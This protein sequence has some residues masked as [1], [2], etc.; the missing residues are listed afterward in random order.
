MLLI[1]PDTF[2]AAPAATSLDICE[3]GDASEH[4]GRRPSV[5]THVGNRT[6]G[7]QAGGACSGLH[8]ALEVDE[9]EVAE[10]S[11]GVGL[12]VVQRRN[13]VHDP[14][15]SWVHGADCDRVV[16]DAGLAGS[17]GRDRGGNDGPVLSRR[18]SPRGGK[19]PCLVM[20]RHSPG[21]K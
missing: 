10:R 17:A 4:V 14:R 8:E 3:V 9:G 18:E 11:G 16:E 12:E 13:D 20:R 19:T 1:A 6:E 21:R 2:D 7:G 15:T 5:T